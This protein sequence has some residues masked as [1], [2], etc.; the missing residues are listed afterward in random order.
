MTDIFLHIP[1]T[2]GTTLASALKWSVYGPGSFCRLET[3]ETL[4]PGEV[5]EAEYESNLSHDVITGHFRYGAHRHLRGP[6][7]YFTMLREPVRRVVSHYYF[8][9]RRKPSSALSQTPL[10]QFHESDHPAA[11]RNRQVFFL[12]D[13]DPAQHPDSSLREAKERLQHEICAFGLTERFDASL[14]LL[15]EQLQWRFPP[16]YLPR[17]TGQNRPTVDALPSQTIEVLRKKNQLDVELYQFAQSRF[18]EGL[19]RQCSDLDRS[20]I[21]FR[22]RNRLVQ[23]VV[24]PL[25]SCYHA[26]R[27]IFATRN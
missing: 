5:F 23:S 4:Q 20:L 14:L 26:A 19:E 6:C 12:S 10:E 9:R 17:K 22:R 27:R 25:F 3:E 21:R 16:F 24:T 18:Q 11:K 1:K 2:G 8:H 15:R 13:Y 7:R